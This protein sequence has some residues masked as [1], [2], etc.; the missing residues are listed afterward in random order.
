MNNKHYLLALNRIPF[1]TSV[2][3]TALLARW[4]DLNELFCLTSSQ[5]IKAGLSE[6][7]AHSIASFNF[8]LIEADLHWATAQNHHILCLWDT[9]YPS[10]LKE[11]PDPPPV[12]Y[13]VGKIE[14][15]QA[16][17][18]AM[19]GTRKP[20]PMGLELAT[21]MAFS[22]ANAGLTVVS[23][24]ALG[25]DGQVHEG[26]LRAN[27]PTVAV[28]GTGVDCIYPRRHLS[29]AKRI[30]QKGLLLSEFPL[31]TP[32]SAR[33]FPRRNRIIS[34]CSL[35]TL[36]VEA[37]KRSG[38]LI[39][40]HLALE[41]NRDVMAVP[42]SVYNTQARGCH[43]LLQEGAKLVTSAEDVISELLNH[44]LVI[45]HGGLD[46]NT[47]AYS[48][49]PGSKRHFEPLANDAENLVQC[50]DGLTTVDQIAARSGL[51]VEY[52]ICAL[53]E[54]EITNTIRAVPGGYMR[55]VHER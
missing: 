32:P 15:L 52:V 40:A 23:G 19:V 45:Q 18:V 21:S 50:I 29:L 47:L 55:C 31:S 37:A 43:Q 44:P 17:M 11:I 8:N 42:G 35:C 28:M 30:T 4:P 33:H 6:R 39:T 1:I 36:V 34:G 51:S 53:A 9:T 22:L 14:C 25:I 24:L 13:A 26:C 27:K 38:S 46:T 7:I 5:M 3:V 2:G 20:T 49:S 54:L 10:L 48:S 16:P 41:Q 12:L